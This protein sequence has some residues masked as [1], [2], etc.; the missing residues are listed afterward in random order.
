VGLEDEQWFAFDFVLAQTA[1]TCTQMSEHAGLQKHGKAAEAALMAEF[2]Q[3]EDL[4]MYKAL[5]PSKLTR[6]QKKAASLWAINLIKEKRNGKIKGCT[7][8]DGCLQR[9]LYSKL[10]T[11]TPTVSTDAL[12]LSIIIE[13]FEARDMATADVAGAYLKVYMDDFVIMRFVGASVKLLCELNPDHKHFVIQENGIDILY[14]RL[15]K[16]L[17][18]CVKS[19]LLWYELFTGSIKDMLGFVLNPYDSCIANCMIKGKQCT[20]VWYVDNTKISH[21]NPN[22][23]TNII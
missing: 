4:D 15:I 2:A 11:A 19:A 8:A 14:V 23:V 16:A 5:D 6:T 3:L 1:T 13:A 18:R 22:V 7:C 10:Q 12:M 17:Y 9:N 20:I 21:V